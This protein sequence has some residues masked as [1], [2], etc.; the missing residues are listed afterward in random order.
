MARD[1]RSSFDWL[2][3]GAPGAANPVAVLEKLC[4]SLVAAGIPLQRVAAF[5]RTL[6]PHVMGRSFSWRPGAPVEIREASHAVLSSPTFLA[7]PVGEVFREGNVFRRRLP[8]PEGDDFAVLKELAEQGMTDYLAVPLRFMNGTVHAITFATAHPEGFSE[9]DVDALKD[10]ARPLSRVAE[11]LALNRTA[12]NLLDTYVGRN[13]GERILQG[14]I[15]RGD[16]DSI[17]CVIWFSDLRGFTSMADSVEPGVLIR[18]LNELFDCQVPS[19]ERQGGEVLKFMGDGMLAIFPIDGRDPG[20]ACQRALE[21]SDSA[22]EALAQLNQARAERGD[23]ALRFGLALHVGDVAY[24]N[25]GGANRLDFTCIGPAINLAARIEA[26]ASKLG[27]SR[28]LSAEMAAHAGRNVHSLGEHELKGVSGK[29][30]VY[31]LS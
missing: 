7:S 31:E 4:P 5:V 11:I 16:T 1:I 22:F 19:I 15:Q 14:H 29:Q 17:R 3:D 12:V 8:Q 2:V 30:T 9:D 21:A 18:T 24:G 23:P 25:I 26:L 27:K 10:I 20:P 13:A 6:H 28:L